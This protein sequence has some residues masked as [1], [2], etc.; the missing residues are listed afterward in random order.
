M[1]TAYGTI[2]LAVEPM[3]LGAA[4]F[5][6]KPFSIEEV[7]VKLKKITADQDFLTKNDPLEKIIGQSVIKE[8]RNLIKRVA[9]SN[10]SVLI[11]GETGTGKEL[12]AAA[13]HYLS[14]RSSYPYY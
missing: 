2:E 6:T 11:Y 9:R 10:S 7:K 13:L 8:V 12:V 4:D 14:P 5:I 1:I 3:K